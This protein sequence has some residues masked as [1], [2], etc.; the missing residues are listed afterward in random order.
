M[1]KILL[2]Q[3]PIEDFYITS[4]RRQPLGLLYLSSYVEKIGWKPILLNCHSA[5]RK[6]MPLPQEFKYLENYIKN[7]TFPFPYYAHWGKSWEEI[8]RNIKYADVDI[9]ATSSMFTTYYQ[10]TDR[11]IDIIRKYHKKP[12]I[13][14]GHHAS[15][16]PDYYTKEKRVDFVIKGEGEIPLLRV[17]KYIETKDINFL[18]DENIISFI[19][20]KNNT[21]LSLEID[22]TVIPKRELLKEKDFKFYKNKRITSIIFSR[23]CPNRCKFCTSKIVFK[24]YKKRSI[25]SL[26]YEIEKCIRE[27]NISVF[28]FED[29]NIFADRETTKEFLDNLVK[30][31]EK[32][33]VEFTAMNGISIEKLDKES[34]EL[35]K[36][37]FNEINISLVS[38][39][40]NTQA[41]YNRPFYTVDIENIIKHAYKIGLK[42]RL[43]FILGLPGQT[44][45]EVIEIKN[46]FKSTNIK[47]FPSVY[48]D[49]FNKTKEE[50][51]I[52][53]SSAFP[54]ETK[55]LSRED[56]I[57]IFNTFI[58][59]Y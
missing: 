31:K 57:N 27:L 37:G 35:M 38:L 11:I 54:N 10:E 36:R 59:E 1:K 58:K 14:G 45:K 40:H 49:L 16:Y 9:F 15:L 52:Q 41:E 34:I 44:K 12:I 13:V 55:E 5:K 7:K 28:N 26:L 17:L 39:Y 18:Y 19:E 47:I 23:G 22:E 32:Y 29:D 30:I 3:P 48:Y 50:W 24:D 8:E 25:N 20:T 33:N 43:Y 53:R 6:I 4:I 56:M 21:P 2:I 46:F 42:I 51:K